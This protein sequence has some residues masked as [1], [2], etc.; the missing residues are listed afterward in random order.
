MWCSVFFCLGWLFVT[1]WPP[2][3]NT[4][5]DSS[6]G[7]L[8]LVAGI[9]AICVTAIVLHSQNRQADVEAKTNEVEFKANLRVDVEMRHLHEQVR[10][11]RAEI[12]K[13]LPEPPA[14]PPGGQGKGGKTP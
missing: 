10:E 4:S 11:L 5:F 7:L 6:V 14:S 2:N 3:T 12:L 13:W 1:L 9:V 8:S